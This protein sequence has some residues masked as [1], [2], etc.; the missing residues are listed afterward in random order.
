MTANDGSRI[1]P[2]KQEGKLLA[3]LLGELRP[4]SRTSVKQLLAQGRITVNGEPTTQFDHPLKPDD[5]VAITREGS[6]PS[7]R[8][9][10]GLPIVYQD[11]ALIVIDKPE[12]LLSVATE[13]ERLDTA[14]ALLNAELTAKQE[15]RPFV[16]HR[17]DRDTSGLLLFARAVEVRDRLQ[18]NWEGV[19]KTYLAVVEGTPN[20]P[21][22]MVRNYLMEGRDLRVRASEKQREG[23]K[24]AVTR[25]KL[26]ETRGPHS[27]MEVVLQTGR[28]HQIRVHLS[29]LGCP[30]IGDEGYGAKTNPAR[31]LGLHAW[32]LAFDHPVTGKRIELESPLPEV[33]QRLIG[34]PGEPGA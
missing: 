7:S 31:R 1:F 23:S 17:L 19:T 2:V 18:A 25:Y 29:G 15:G 3:W 10:A 22:G 33:L 9:P 34:L 30:I 14:F 12:G 11:D 16:V 32:R 21:E 27:L 5:R 26:L 24:H 28:K 20:P 8:K 4:M 13:I 6:G